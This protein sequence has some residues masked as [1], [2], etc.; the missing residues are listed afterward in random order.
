M[1]LAVLFALLLVDLLCIRIKGI[2]ST[3]DWYTEL[4]WRRP[5]VQRVQLVED[6]LRVQR[7]HCCPLSCDTPK[8]FY[9]FINWNN[10]P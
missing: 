6:R 9:L 8:E 7:T 3:G 5:E 10:F 4:K 2:V 1:V